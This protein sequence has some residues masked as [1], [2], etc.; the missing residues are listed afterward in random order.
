MC[1]ICSGLKK[2]KLSL[3]DAIK[4]YEEF[5]DLDLID[6]EHQEEVE[7]LISEREEEEYH[8]SSAKKDYFR[9]KEDYVDRDY[10]EDILIE[11]YDEDEDE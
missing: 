2:N 3:Q 10:D 1:M 8:W 6:E 5:L 7:E 11:D 9:S 4:K